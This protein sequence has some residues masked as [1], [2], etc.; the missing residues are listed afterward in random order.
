MFALARGARDRLLQIPRRLAAQL[1]AKS[2]QHEVETML[3]QAVREALADLETLYA[4]D[5]SAM[6]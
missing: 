1:A 5:N 4:P 2:D 6:R 3:E